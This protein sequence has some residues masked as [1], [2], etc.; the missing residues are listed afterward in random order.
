MSFPTIPDITPDINIKREDAINL[1]LISIALEE[2]SMADLI[3]AEVKKICSVVKNDENKYNA[4]DLKE[5]NRSVDQTLKDIIKL[6][7]L[8]QFKLENV[9]EIPCSCTTTSSTSSTTTTTTTTT[10]ST[11]TTT[12][13]TT[14]TATT[15]STSTTTTTT[16]TT[17]TMTTTTTTTTKSTTS[18]S[19]TT[20][21]KKKCKCYMIGTAQGCVSKKCDAFF[22]GTACVKTSICSSCYGKWNNL[23]SYCTRKDD[24]S[25]KI[26]A[27]PCD[28]KIE[29]HSIKN[30]YA[31]K[32]NGKCSIVREICSQ[33]DIS[34]TGSFE[35][36]IWDTFWANSFRMVI[37]ADNKPI[38]DHDS[39]KVTINGFGPIIGK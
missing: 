16:K 8:L 3:D 21:A 1:L 31:I 34:D 28:L 18:T 17:T 23:L 22:G 35:L 11:S 36:T 14:I 27:F 24:V 26:K 20:T 13:T 9:Q 33:K 4:N 15:T 37:T 32:I 5:I 10:T 7:M 29:C 19:T 6:Q 2:M 25:E 39:G 30:P 12:T 38:L